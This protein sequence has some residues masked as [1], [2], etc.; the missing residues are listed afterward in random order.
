MASVDV[1]DLLQLRNITLSRAGS[2]ISV[3]IIPAGGAFGE[4]MHEIPLEDNL[5]WKAIVAY[6]N[7]IS[8]SAH[9]VISVE[10]N[11][12]AGA[13]LGGGSS[14]A[15]AV[16]RLLNG[17]LKEKSENEL[18]NIAA[19]IGAD[20]PFCLKGG[21]A[22]CEGIGDKIEDL[23]AGLNHWVVIAC[24]DVKVDTA[25]AYRSLNRSRRERGASTVLERKRERMR[26]G[27][28]SGDIRRIRSL[29]RNDFEEMICARYPV[30]GKARELMLACEPDFAVMTGSGSALVGLFHE[31]ELAEQAERR[32]REESYTVFFTKFL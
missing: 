9:V 30:I 16:L 27:V 17:Y 18:F 14:D 11:I 26:T 7:G 31:R 1:F 28:Q 13:G 3:E 22:F 2:A 25:E 15:A 29:M 23:N 20:V 12:P 21:F 24:S 19:T 5:I 8:Q 10:K 4:L 6:L 32:L